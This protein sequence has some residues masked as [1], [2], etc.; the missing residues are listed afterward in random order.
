M[1]GDS[2][3]VAELMLRLMTCSIEEDRV[4]DFAAST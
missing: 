2:S 1:V 3:D 4:L